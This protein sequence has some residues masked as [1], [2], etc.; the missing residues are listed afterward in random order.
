MNAKKIT[1]KIPIHN[2]QDDE[3][4]SYGQK[5]SYNNS[6][7]VSSGSY[8]IYDYDFYGNPLYTRNPTAFNEVTTITYNYNDFIIELR[9]IEDTL[10]PTEEWYQ[11]Q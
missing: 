7:S 8:F 11:S 5:K 1:T 10:F 6:P 9:K 2:A 4:D 3:Y